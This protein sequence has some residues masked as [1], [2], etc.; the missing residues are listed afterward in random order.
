MHTGL[1]SL[2][3]ATPYHAGSYRTTRAAGHG[4]GLD[5]HQQGRQVGTVEL[6]VGEG[7]EPARATHYYA[8]HG[9][10]IA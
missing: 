6:Q 7:G 9:I 10:I 3:R 5:R 1:V 2:G 4:R 8:L